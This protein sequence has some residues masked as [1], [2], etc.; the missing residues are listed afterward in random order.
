VNT[1]VV[2]LRPTEHGWTVAGYV[3]P[4]CVRQLECIA[5]Q[6][7]RGVAAAPAQTVS[8]PVRRGTSGC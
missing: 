7:G 1:G 3:T 8:G 6:N 2:K 4:A 5:S